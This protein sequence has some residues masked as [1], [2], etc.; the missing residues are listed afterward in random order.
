MGSLVNKKSDW[1]M[2][3]CDLPNQFQEESVKIYSST[4]LTKQTCH[5]L[6][7]DFT[8]VTY[9]I[10]HLPEVQNLEEFQALLFVFEH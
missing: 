8:T 5:S 4:S 10:L 1:M 3:Y 2:I 6:L 7:L 9:D